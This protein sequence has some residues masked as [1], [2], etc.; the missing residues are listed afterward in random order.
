VTATPPQLRGLVIGWIAAG[1]I[2]G[3]GPVIV[4]SGLDWCRR[5]GAELQELGNSLG[6]DYS[7]LNGAA[8][9]HVP[10]N[11]NQQQREAAYWAAMEA[12]PTYRA[13]CDEVTVRRHGDENWT[14]PPA[15]TRTPAPGG[16]P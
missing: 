5:H 9:D 1:L 16:R 15:P 7:A 12:N 11:G 6:V 13:L 10:P 4:D 2:A 3:C 8:M 14:A